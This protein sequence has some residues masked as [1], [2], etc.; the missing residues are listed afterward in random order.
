MKKKLSIIIP[1]YNEENTIQA[2]LKRISECKIYDIDFE[3]IIINDGSTDD[4]LKIIKKR[5]Y[6]LTC[7]VTKT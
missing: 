7:M 1:V 3:I 2:I 4:T 6:F 5:M